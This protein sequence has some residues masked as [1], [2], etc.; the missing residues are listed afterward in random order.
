MGKPM[1]LTQATMI[2]SL[3]LSMYT[4]SC[5]SVGSGRQDRSC[6]ASERAALL[7]IKEKLSDPGEQLSSWQGEECCSWKGIRCSNRTGHVVEL[8]L[9]GDRCYHFI[10]DCLGGSEFTST[11]SSLQHSNLTAL[12]IL[13]ISDN[14]FGSK[15]SPN[16]FWD[17]T[18]LKHLDISWSH[19]HGPLFPDDMRN[20]TALEEIHLAGNN[21]RGENPSNLKNLCNMK[22]IDI[23][24]LEI[25]KDISELREWLPKCSWIKLRQLDLSSNNFYGNLPD[26][27][28]LLTNLTY[29]DFQDNKLTGYTPIWLG[30]LTKLVVL[31]LSSNYLDGA[32]YEDHFKGL[33][34]LKVLGLAYNSLVMTV[35]S[36]WIPPFR[37]AIADLRSSRLGPRIPAWLRSQVGIQMLAMSNASITD[38]VPDWFWNLVSGATFLDLSK[39]QL[40]GMLPERMELMEAHLIDLSNNRL[41]GPV[42]KFPRKAIYIDFSSNSLSEKLPTDFATEVLYVLALQ[43]NSIS[44]T[45][46]T[47]MCKMRYIRKLDLS[48]NMLTGEVPSCAQQA[49]LNDFNEM[50]SLKLN[51]N[52]LSGVFP[53]F[54]QMCPKI[55]FVDLAYNQFSG[56]LPAW[57]QKMAP[58]LALLRLRSNM[59]S[60]QIPI[61]YTKFQRLQYLDIAYNYLSGE[62]PTSIADLSAM[63]SPGDE[64]SFQDMNITFAPTY[65]ALDDLI[66]YT[67]STS[68]LTKG[69]Q[70]DYSKQ[71]IYMV[72]LDLSCNRLTGTIPV[73]ISALVALKNVNLSWNNLSGGIPDNIGAIKELESLDLSHNRLSGEIPS[74]ISTMIFLSHINLS[75]NNLSGRIPTGNQLQ[76]LEDPA[77]IYIGNINLCG[78]PLANTCPDNR[79]RMPIYPEERQGEHQMPSHLSV[80]IGF[81]LGLWMV[82]CVMLL[83]RR[84]RHAYFVF[85]DGHCY[86]I[87]ETMVCVFHHK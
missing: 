82:F 22:V 8:D 29:I 78:P 55:V 65:G 80:I 37:L 31:Q 17:V 72:N 66:F 13:D 21:L 50:V 27:L 32:I 20:M 67:E 11:P 56:I 5:S 40:T 7:S 1:F 12:E 86:R 35:S 57:L 79:T 28:K 64:S 53:S 38:S 23:A 30:T 77:S 14:K 18:N 68:V 33:A 87:L 24:Y 61:Q 60:G 25:T 9:R 84:W 59:F 19:F 73:D 52:N 63:N 74:S 34:N 45:I 44:G 2:I 10:I 3:L 49:D 83:S 75:Y 41:F 47:S 70:L 62:I 39:N 54:L 76:T 42:Q 4:S 26:W 36:D 81:I 48:N 58:F 51:D 6:I 69:Q 71:I 85:I 43:N 46:P 15:I 16:W